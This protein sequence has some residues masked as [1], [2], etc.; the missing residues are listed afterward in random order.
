VD[1]IASRAIGPGA[2]ETWG[3]AYEVNGFVSIRVYTGTGQV[4]SIGTWYQDFDGEWE[5]VPTTQATAVTDWPWLLWDPKP[6]EW[7][8]Y[9]GLDSRLCVAY[10]GDGEQVTLP[11]EPDGSYTIEAFATGLPVIAS[12]LGS[13]A[14]L[15]DHRRTG[16]HFRAGDAHDLSEK[17]AWAVD[18]P[19]GMT[20]M[21]RRARAA[22]L[23]R[24]TAERNLPLMLELYRH[25]VRYGDS[26]TE[27]TMP[28]FPDVKRA[29]GESA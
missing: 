20:E 27:S 16:L 2:P 1:E 15:V 21:G 13:A 9:P 23:E 3:E 19:A 4:D 12:D 24:F 10:G 11:R 7:N 29:R 25:A 22:F 28:R 6:H 5:S 26:R 8:Q 14:E 18:H 17:V